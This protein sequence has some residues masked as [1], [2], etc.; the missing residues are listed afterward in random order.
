[1]TTGLVPGHIQTA[2]EFLS[3][4]KDYLAQG[5]LHQAAEKGWGAAAHIAKAIAFTNGW[6]YDRHDQFDTVIRNA[7]QK[8]RQSNLWRYGDS[9][10]GLHRFYYQHPSV[11]DADAIRDRTSDVEAM[12]NALVPYLPD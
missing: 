12:F 7:G 4:S 3:R 9:A 5:D 8:Y 6:E 1:M 2:R 11:L 10:H